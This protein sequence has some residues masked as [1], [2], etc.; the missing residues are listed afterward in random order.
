MA[1]VHSDKITV[2]RARLALKCLGLYNKVTL[3]YQ[4]AHRKGVNA[5]SQGN[6][7][8]DA[9]AREATK[10]VVESS[11]SAPMALSTA[12][13]LIKSKI[14]AEWR[15]EWDWYGEA[16]QAHYFLDGPSS[17]FNHIYKYNRTSMSRLVQYITGHAFLRRHNKI[18]E[19]G[20]KDHNDPKDCRLC[21]KDEETP[22][23]LITKCEVLALHR[24]SLFGKQ[25]L[26][27]YFHNW[28]VPQMQY[29]LDQ[30]DFYDLEMPEY[31]NLA[32]IDPDDDVDV[33]PVR[34]GVVAGR[35][36]GE[37]DVPQSMGLV[38]NQQ[39]S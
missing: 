29:Y 3:I 11:I 17:K 6:E 38:R 16:R 8:P 28:R 22:H 37:N 9:A 27:M 2:K 33:G 7:L 32:D 30:G 10:I 31:D 4:R 21:G 24:F 1:S 18:V 36:V 34:V 35:D 26:D 15:R 14:W 5:A 19:H 39:P 13:S 23:H 12:K 25:E 20:T